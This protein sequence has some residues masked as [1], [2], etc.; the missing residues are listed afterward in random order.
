[1]SVKM[2]WIKVT[3]ETMPPDMEEVIATIRDGDGKK[4]V[5]GNIRWNSC[6]NEFE[7][8]SSGYEDYWVSACD[9]DETVTHWMPYPAPAED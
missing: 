4:H 7:I 9:E 1:M 3:P 6:Y 2:G 8:L 5:Y